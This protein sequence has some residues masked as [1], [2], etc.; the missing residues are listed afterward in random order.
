LLIWVD[1]PATLSLQ[2]FTPGFYSGFPITI[3]KGI[4]L[5]TLNKYPRVHR[6]PY[7]LVIT[8]CVLFFGAFQ[9]ASGQKLDSIER[10]RSM[11]MLKTI[12]DDLKKNYYDPSF[13]GMD[14][15]ARF[16]AAEEK[17]K[18]ATSVGQAF[19]IIAQALLDLDDSHTK[20]YPPSRPEKID[21]G[22]KM[23]MIGD[24][25]HIVAVRPG[26]DADKQGLKPGDRVLALERRKPTR[27]DL[28]KMNYYYNVLS[29]RPG[30]QV[31]VQSPGGA[32]R[33]LNL[34]AK[35]TRGQRVI[36]LTTDMGINTFLRELEDEDRQE[37]RDRYYENIAGVFV[38]KMRR[39]YLSDGQVDAMMERV[40][41]SKALVL[42]L[43]DNG[44]GAEDTL[45]RLLG[46]FF[47]KDVKMADIKTRKESKPIIAKT[48]GKNPFNGKVVVLI[49]SKSG[50]AAEIFA[51]IMQLEKRG[52][53]IGD[54]S[55]GAVM[56]SISHPYEMGVNKVVSYGA[57]ITVADA[58]MSDGQSLEHVGVVP[59]ELLLP[60][61]EDLAAQKD[62]VLARA[63]ELTGAKLDAAKAGA[64]FPFEWK[65]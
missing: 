30:L 45:L 64:L 14:L 50:S 20:F 46:H 8:V 21:Y 5:V 18:Q 44:G 56:R 60:S 61:P 11:D 58:L 65:N 55:A 34:E 49:D 48:R 57:S 33:E 35:V 12:K 19:G 32:P 54:R 26:S 1:A 9:S 3:N 53:V 24:V 6:Y 47:D 10:Q 38:W 62:P 25:P 31:V 22:W 51:R 2:F 17:L 16:N 59:D 36:D 27:K 28:W 43:R 13:H 52:T 63:L 37:D 4:M 7:V 41:K 15:D 40:K 23:Q 42:D 39:F 29:P